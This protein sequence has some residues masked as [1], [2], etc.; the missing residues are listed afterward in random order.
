MPQHPA[1]S[2]P[3][4]PAVNVRG[5]VVPSTSSPQTSPSRC[6]AMSPTP[7]AARAPAQLARGQLAPLQIVPPLRRAVAR[8][9]FGMVTNGG[10]ARGL[11]AMTLHNI[12]DAQRPPGVPL[13]RKLPRSAL[14][15]KLPLVSRSGLSYAQSNPAAPS[16]SVFGQLAE[17]I[18]R[19]RNRQRAKTPQTGRLRTMVGAI[20]QNYKRL[21]C[22]LV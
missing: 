16:G 8:Q 10:L 2:A 12:G 21:R 1:R 17:T 6:S 4:L 18:V 13:G 5:C 19:M 7:A 9:S 15:R 3:T 22:W 20:R 11:L 14:T